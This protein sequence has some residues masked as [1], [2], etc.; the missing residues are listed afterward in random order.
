MGEAEAD[1]DLD[2][3]EVEA[4]HE[5]E[6]G[7][8]LEAVEAEADLDLDMNELESDH[9]LEVEADLDLV[10]AEGRGRPPGAPVSRSS[11]RSCSCPCR[12]AG[13]AGCDGAA[14]ARSAQANHKERD[15]HASKKPMMPRKSAVLRKTGPRLFFS[16]FSDPNT[17]FSKMT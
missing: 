5:V 13:H 2:M 8:D 16:I 14:R 7:L 17:F 11:R 12:G 4:D 9:D 3:V 1:R 15:Q 10:G 6:A